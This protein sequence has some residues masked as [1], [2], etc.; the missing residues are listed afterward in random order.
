LVVVELH[1]QLDVAACD[2]AARAIEEAIASAPG[3]VV[4][5]LEGL[6]FMD[7]TGVRCLFKAKTLADE[8]GIRLAVLNGSGPAHRVLALIRIAD[9][10]EMVDAFDEL[11]PPGE[12]GRL[13]GS[14]GVGHRPGP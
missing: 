7:S 10:I 1:G 13:A 5:D 2:E 6:S 3:G 9:G 4:V 12:E 8:A 11:V 14:G